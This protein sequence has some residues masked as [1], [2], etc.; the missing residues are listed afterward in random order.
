MHYLLKQY[1]EAKYAKGNYCKC[2]RCGKSV[3]KKSQNHV[4]CKIQ[5]KNRFWLNVKGKDTG[6]GIKPVYPGGYDQWKKDLRVQEEIIAEQIIFG[7]E[8]MRYLVFR[9]SDDQP[10][11]VFHYEDHAETFMEAHSE[12][13]D[14]KE[15]DV[16]EVHEYI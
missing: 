14:M 1:V 7:E 13:C 4:F 2:P 3:I 11:A 12:D 16:E 10:L 8:T 15:I 6:W 9:V 5:C